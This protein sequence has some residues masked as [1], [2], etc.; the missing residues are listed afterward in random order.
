MRGITPFCMMCLAALAAGCASSRSGSAY[1][2]H[3]ARQ[4][5]TVRFGIV[6]SVREVVIEGTRSPAGPMAGAALGGLAGSNIG[7]G[8]GATAGAIVGAV[9]GG[10][11]GAAIEES[12]TRRPGLEITVRLES[13][14]YIAVTQEADEA[15]HPGERVRVL[16]GGGASRI[17]H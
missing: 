13:G 8:R 9:A 7:G 16:R 3:Q 15:F 6:E 5:M 2:R 11:A 4:E 12:A 10:V 1:E 17:S 14:Q